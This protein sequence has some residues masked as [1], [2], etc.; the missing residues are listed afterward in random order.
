M[1]DEENQEAALISNQL[2][3]FRLA[4]GLSQQALGDVLNI[5][6]DFQ[7]FSFLVSQRQQKMKNG[8]Y[9]TERQLLNAL[10]IKANETKAID[11]LEKKVNKVHEMFN[12]HLHL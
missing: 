5:K 8:S 4:R 9:F 10:S 12:T 7:I 6:H 11:A 3:K 2:K 1:E